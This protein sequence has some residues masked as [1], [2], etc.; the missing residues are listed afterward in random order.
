MPLLTEQPPLVF[1][2]LTGLIVGV[3]VLVTYLL[4]QRRVRRLSEDNTRLTVQL[5]AQKELAAQRFAE[6]DHSRQVLSDHFAALSADV[7][8]RNSEA[9]LRLA[10]ESL[11]QHHVRAEADLERREQSI[12]AMVAPIREALH[13]TER[14]IQLIENERKQAYGALTQHLQS[15]AQTQSKPENSCSTDTGRSAHC[16]PVA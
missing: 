6:R 2:L 1:A 4:V 7:L 15:L 5:E 3:A 8:G 16:P 12:D 10:Q 14:Q 9:F 11:K 13:K